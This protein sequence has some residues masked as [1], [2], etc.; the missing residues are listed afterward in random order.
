MAKAKQELKPIN[1]RYVTVRIIG[2]S[3]LIQHKWSEKA[4]IM[5][6][7]KQQ[8]GK[9]TKVR[10]LREPEEEG[11]AAGYYTPDGEPGLLAVA[12]KASIITAAHQDLGFAKTLIRKALFIHPMGREV[13]IPMEMPTGKGK[14]KQCIEED[15]VR[16]GAGS[17]DL[18]Y[19]PYY[20]EWAA[21]TKWEIDSDLLQVNDLLTLIDRAGFGVGI[22]EWRPEKDGEYGRFMID[23]KFDV[24]DEAV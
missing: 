5:M 10:D 2:I 3:P 24:V 18:R 19:R 11:K 16:V 12:I 22:H 14:V 9:K 15:M 13:V 20:Y 6:R 7:D 23:P 17:A 21:I 1:R 8:K 4:K